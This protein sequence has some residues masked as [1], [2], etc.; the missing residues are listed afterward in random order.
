MKANW[1]IILCALS[2]SLSALFYY[3]T[4]YSHKSE[5]P[6]HV[7]RTERSVKEIPIEMKSVTAAPKNESHANPTRTPSSSFDVEVDHAH[8]TAVQIH[9]LVEKTLAEEAAASAKEEYSLE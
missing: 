4:N 2:I 1:F 3:P 6:S 5:P 7:N 9:S 8:K